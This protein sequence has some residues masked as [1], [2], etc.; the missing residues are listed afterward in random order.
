LDFSVE[1]DPTLGSSPVL[2]A[3]VIS[4]NG[5]ALPAFADPDGV[6][7]LPALPAGPFQLRLAAPTRTDDSVRPRQP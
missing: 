6:L 4:A 2:G 1:P 5:L 7:L 3:L